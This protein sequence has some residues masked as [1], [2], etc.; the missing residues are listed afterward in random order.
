MVNKHWIG[1]L[2]AVCLFL[3]AVVVLFYMA[4][5]ENIY[6]KNVS[7]ITERA[8]T[9]IAYTR[10]QITQSEN[11]IDAMLELLSQSH[12]LHDFVSDPTDANR[13][14]VEA[15]WSTFP[16]RQYS[17]EQITY[18][19]ADGQE[20][21]K[22]SFLHHASVTQNQAYQDVSEASYFIRARQWPDKTQSPRQLELQQ[23]GEEYIPH[24][25]TVHPYSMHGVLQG[26]LAVRRNY[27]DIQSDRESAL[28]QQY[29]VSI[30]T[31]D[32]DF[33]QGR[34]RERLYGF[35]LKE[36]HKY[37]LSKT[38][39]ALWKKMHDRESGV[40]L[41]E[42]GSLHIYSTVKVNYI[43][44]LFLLI[45]FPQSE[46]VAQVEDDRSSA[47]QHA[48]VMIILIVLCALPTA[49]LIFIYQRRSLES[50]LATAAL[51]GMS[52]VLIT[53][54]NHHMVKV[55][56]EFESM[57]GYTEH[58]IRYGNVRKLLFDKRDPSGWFNIWEH[59]SREH[60][61]EGELKV[62]GR[63]GVELTTI[64][65]IQALCDQD[66]KITNYIISLVDITERKELEERLRYLSERD[67]LTHLW[68]RRKFEEE[69]RNE[70]DLIQRYPEN[71]ISCLALVDIDNFKR[72]NDERGHDEGDR[73]IRL[74]SHLL[75]ENTRTTD[76]VARIGG[77]EFAIIMPHTG[78]SE[79]ERV[80]NRIRSCIATD[81]RVF[82]TIS[83]GV[84]DLTSD[85]T[86]SYKCADIALYES[87]AIGRNRTSVCHSSDEIA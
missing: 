81:P 49:Y 41:S 29:I 57:T 75:S 20:M 86:R 27:A 76:F 83:I 16:A 19:D 21:A 71:H 33:L 74:V 25:Y 43:E 59:V 3:G 48:L 66:G 46:L 55:N 56:R 61:W 2:L 17:L 40:F 42:N 18:I 70:T 77:E 44:D 69:L 78:L 58:Q 37:N 11:E 73:V 53:D 45:S 50:K 5:Y 14:T 51:N 80:L 68:N 82:T 87:K 15:S 54:K 36:R 35:A 24:L 13:Q 85:G 9:Q 52:A 28:K 39:P 65:R 32:G 31:A 84:T 64:T 34:Y 12:L 63:A 67:G 38:H 6:Q 10:H 62:H 22:A 47:V 8:K 79:A 30:I 4:K 72:I 60:L 7:A 1:Y 26:Y 23:M